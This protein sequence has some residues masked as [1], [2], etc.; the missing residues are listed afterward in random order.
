ML[1]AANV[2]CYNV[3]SVNGYCSDGDFKMKFPQTKEYKGYRIYWEEASCGA[4]MSI[5]NPSNQCVTVEYIGMYSPGRNP[6]NMIDD[7]IAAGLD[8]VKIDE[9]KAMNDDIW[10]ELEELLDKEFPGPE[11][12]L[13][14]VI[15]DD[16]YCNCD[17]PEIVKSQAAG[18]FFD[19]CRA[20]KKEKK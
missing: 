9:T 4:K 15:S 16:T 13:P 12:E 19:Y 8:G 2:F 18:M 20:C 1:D 10:K 7:R 17:N 5:F 6:Y 11:L 3:S 14:P